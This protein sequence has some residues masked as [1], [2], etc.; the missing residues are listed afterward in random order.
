MILLFTAAR[1]WL[2]RRH[3]TAP[4]PPITCQH[5]DVTGACDP[6][7]SAANPV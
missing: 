1:E 7:S 6:R 2:A 3:T 5:S 4:I